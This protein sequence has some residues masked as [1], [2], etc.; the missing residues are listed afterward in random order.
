MR[1]PQPGA[2]SAAPLRAEKRRAGNP[3]RPSACTTR[4]SHSVEPRADDGLLPISAGQRLAVSAA[5]RTAR[6]V[7]Y[8]HIPLCRTAL[9][10]HDA[11]TG[12]AALRRQ[13]AARPSAFSTDPSGSLGDAT[14]GG[15]GAASSCRFAAGVT[16]RGATDVPPGGAEVVTDAR[17]S[18]EGSVLSS[19]WPK[20]STRRTT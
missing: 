20:D 19:S 1:R 11:A 13:A 12:G 14:V 3:W 10:V 17:R 15:K 9:T 18:T 2:R 7:T 16:S 4:R 8:T 6:A 5:R